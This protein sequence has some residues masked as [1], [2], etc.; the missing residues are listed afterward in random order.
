MIH[1]MA[2]LALGMSPFVFFSVYADD[3]QNEWTITIPNG[4]SNQDLGLAIYPNELP[5]KAGD[6]ITWHNQDD[7]LHSITSGVPT[8]PD[9]AGVFFNAGNILPGQSSSVVLEE[10]EFNAYHYFC[11]IHPWLTGN[12]FFG[13]TLVAQPESTE[14]IVADKL[15]YKDGDMLTVSGTVHQ[16]FAK[17]DYTYLVYN[18]FNDLVYLSEGSFDDN[19]FYSEEIF[20]DERWDSNGDYKI[21][22]VYGVPSKVAQTTFGFSN[23]MFTSNFE[24]SIPMWIKSVGGFWCSGQISDMEFIDGV[25]YLIDENV[26]RVEATSNP[27]ASS[28]QVPEWVKNTACWWSEN[29]ISDVEFISGIEFLVNI[30][31]ISV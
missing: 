26:I 10:S 24:S 25:Q 7:V 23:S 4:A 18:Q 27:V 15:N 12:I 28:K 17:T 14:P 29:Q 16:D 3:T 8:H 22:L 11:E 30:G 19:A 5:M 20:A 9:F 31:S 21:K 13:D 6:I 2:V 1:L